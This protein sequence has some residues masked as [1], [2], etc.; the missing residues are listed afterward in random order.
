MP[1]AVQGAES[2]LL[3]ATGMAD[4]RDSTEQARTTARELFIS[5]GTPDAVAECCLAFGWGMLRHRQKD[6][7]EFPCLCAVSRSNT[8][9]HPQLESGS[10]TMGSGD[11]IFV[12]SVLLNLTDLIHVY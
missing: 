8:Q 2:M 5:D 1:G 9:V 10:M 3:P 12:F 7:S 11:L 4:S 6:G